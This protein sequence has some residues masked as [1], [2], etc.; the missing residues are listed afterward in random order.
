[1]Q[2]YLLTC[3]DKGN[4]HSTLQS[5][6]AAVTTEEEARRYVEE[7]EI[8]NKGNVLGYYHG[9]KTIEVFDNKDDAIK[10]VLNKWYRVKVNKTAK[11]TAKEII[12]L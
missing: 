3:D 9:Y 6:G 7:A 4:T 5:I 2:I 10:Y 8:P 1:M 12:R 11:L